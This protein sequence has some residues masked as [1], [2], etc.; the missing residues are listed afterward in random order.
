M[1]REQYKDFAKNDRDVVFITAKGAIVY[2]NILM[3]P[4]T[5]EDQKKKQHSR[6]IP[7]VTSI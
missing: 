1:L 5:L 4:N 3:A 6:S 2:Y 7:M